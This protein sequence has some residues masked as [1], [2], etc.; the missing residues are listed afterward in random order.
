[1]K[2]IISILSKHLGHTISVIDT[3]TKIHYAKLCCDTCGNHRG[4]RFLAWL[5]PVQLLGMGHYS[6]EDQMRQAITQKKKIKQRLAK[7]KATVHSKKT[8]KWSQAQPQERNF[9]KSYQPLGSLGRSSTP[10]QLIGDRLAVEGISK[11]NGN[12]VYSIP[13]TYLKQ[14]LKSGKVKR[15]EEQKLIQ[16]AIEL[17]TGSHS[18]PPDSVL[19]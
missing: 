14:L 17:Q 9:Y 5:G 11:Y 15:K 12:S 13:T 2:K 6:S 3:P 7:Q 18:A 1:M 16:A 10:P 8:R 4:T 19:H